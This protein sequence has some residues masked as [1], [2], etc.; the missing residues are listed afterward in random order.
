MAK[1]VHGKERMRSDFDVLVDSD[2]FVGWMLPND[3]HHDQVSQ[4]FAQLEAEEQKLVATNFVIGETA[5]VLSHRDGHHTAQKFLQMIDEIRFPVVHIDEALQEKSTQ[6]FL[7]QQ[8]KGVSMTDCANVVM[9][10]FLHIS[11]I[12]SFD[13]FYFR[14]TIKLQPVQD[15]QM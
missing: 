9:M 6:L 3:A 2:A 5:T 8:N 15:S 1:T 11:R 7:A 10:R 12:F 13:R 4:L 14:D